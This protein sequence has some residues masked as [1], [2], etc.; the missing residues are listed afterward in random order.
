[1]SFRATAYRMILTTKQCSHFVLEVEASIILEI[2]IA[3]IE[4]MNKGFTHAWLLTLVMFVK[5]SREWGMLRREGQ[6]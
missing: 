4:T 1:M 6:R 5:H 3:G 2:F